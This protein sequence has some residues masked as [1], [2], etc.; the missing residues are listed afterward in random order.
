MKKIMVL[1]ALLLT[2]NSYALK[3]EGIN[4]IEILAINGEKVKSDAFSLKN[5][6]E[7]EA[8]LP[9]NCIMVFKRF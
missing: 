6:F 4:G 3:L 5:E 8:W 1:L 9:S 2:Q 7:A